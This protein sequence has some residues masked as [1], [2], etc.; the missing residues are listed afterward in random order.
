MNG[1]K[2]TNKV[3]YGVALGAIVTVA[4]WVLKDFFQIE[5]PPAVQGSLQTMLVFTAQWWVTDSPS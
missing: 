2:P 5:I 1:N 4:S 3:A